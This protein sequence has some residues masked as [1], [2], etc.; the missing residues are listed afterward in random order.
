MIPRLLLLVLIF[1]AVF[2]GKVIRVLVTHRPGSAVTAESSAAAASASSG[3]PASGTQVSSS[4]GSG[5]TD[6]PDT[7][8][9]GSAGTGNGTTISSSSQG[10]SNP[11]DAPAAGLAGL[12]SYSSRESEKGGQQTQ[13]ETSPGASSSTAQIDSAKVVPLQSDPVDDSY[14]SNAVFIGDSRMEGFRNASGITQGTFLTSVGLSINDMSKATISTSS[15]TISVYQGLSGKQ[16]DRIYMMLGTNDLGYYPWDSFQDQFEGVLEQF[17]ALQPSAQ[18]YVCSVIYLEESK[19]SAS[20]DYD[21]NENVRKINGY[22][23]SACEDLWYS[24]Y[25]NLNE[26]LSDG[27]GSLIAG[28]SADGIHLQP[29]YCEVMLKYL[30]THYIDDAVWNAAAG[31]PDS[32]S[33]ASSADVQTEA[34]SGRSESET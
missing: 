28:A 10:L 2:E 29:E 24:W 3:S 34:D 12:A 19:I 25:L 32:S 30:K 15:G 11:S 8:T 26:V 7:D 9:S 31:G 22:L 18:I 5:Q 4:D 6:S 20:Y 33:T 27:Y 1:T 21:N 17:H 13:S 23:V 14:F 16:Y